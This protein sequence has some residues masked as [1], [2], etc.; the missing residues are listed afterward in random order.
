MATLL[1]RRDLA[2]PL[3]A[4]PLLAQTA[5]PPVP[6]SAEAELQAARDNTRQARQ[7]LA[8]YEVPLDIEPAFSF[9]VY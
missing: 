3:I 7:K 5:L 6:A 4:A 8:A 1:R 2:L 9:R